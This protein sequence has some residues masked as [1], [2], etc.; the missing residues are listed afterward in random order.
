MTD[1]TW[2]RAYN[3][4]YVRAAYFYSDAL[5][6]YATV[7]AGTI[8]RLTK[9]TGT[10]N[11]GDS[12]IYDNGNIGIGTTNPLAELEVKD[13][14]DA[15]S[16][17]VLA[18]TS[19]ASNGVSQISFGDNTSNYLWHLSNRNDLDSDKLVLFKGD[20]AAVVTFT[21]TG[22]VGIGSTSPGRPLEVRGAMTTAHVMK[23]ENTNSAATND[24]SGLYIIL[25][26]Y[27]NTTHKFATFYSGASPVGRIRYASATSVAYATTGAGDFAE[28]METD[29]PTEAGDIL[30][31]RSNSIVGLANPG[32]GIAGIHSTA[33]TF[34]AGEENK[35]KPYSAPLAVSGIVPLKVN[36][37][38]GLIRSG[39]PIALS[40]SPGIGAKALKAGYII[41][42]S[43][44]DY[45]NSDPNQIGKIKVL[46]SLSW[47]DP[48]ALLTDTNHLQLASD[49]G[50]WNV[51]VPATGETITRA[52]AF[53]EAMIGRLDTGYLSTSNLKTKDVKVEGEITT[54]SGASL[55]S[56]GTWTDAA[57]ASRKTDIAELTYGLAELM[58]LSPVSFTD[59][60]SGSSG[61]GFIAQEVKR[62]LP[63][64]VYGK[65][66]NYNISYGQ[67]NT[68]L[69]KAIQEQQ[70]QVVG[71]QTIVQ[72]LDLNSSGD[73][74]I[75][76]NKNNTSVK[77]IQSGSLIKQIAALSELVVGKL[78]A[79]I[80]DT[81]Q[82]LVKGV[83]IMEKITG[84]E[85]QVKAQQQQIDELQKQ[86]KELQDKQSP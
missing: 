35:D 71:L 78:K 74:A 4:K 85:K 75:V 66:G 41:G 13:G 15:G 20:G 42:R 12:T 65:E 62:I 68:L 70:T 61:I 55:T 16:H 22:Y 79:G 67:L 10:Y 2:I 83:D 27:T 26:N 36:S 57:D 59:I 73:I 56:S 44:E 47:Y 40:S 28:I 51:E 58:Q 17:T 21:Q 9:W 14:A 34:V 30:A 3:N 25:N 18:L 50:L 23:I 39:D 77:H 8:N 31:F 49:G 60:T 69:T 86:I 6:A 7:G 32:Q 11:Q 19:S 82:I 24:S 37:S 63:E 45:T 48:D 81:Q 80:I 52:A 5:S 29:G 64:I 72:N 76:V 84:L 53:S 46:V 54:S 33:P 38:Q 43:L 1:T